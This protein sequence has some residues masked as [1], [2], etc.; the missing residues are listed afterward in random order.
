MLERFLLLW[1][2]ASSSVAYAWPAIASRLPSGLS[3]LGD[4]FLASKPALPGLIA[5]TMFC[6]GLMLPRDEVT[7]VFRRWPTVFGGTA[8]QYSVMPLFAFALGKLLGFS[9]PEFIG[10]V[11]VGCVP[12]AMASNV[13]T[14]NARGNT[15]YSVSLTTAATLLSPLVVP[16]VLAIALR[17]EQSVDTSVLQAASMMLLLTVVLPVLAGHILS[18]L[19]PSLGQKSRRFGAIVANLA[20]L[21]IIAVVVGRNRAHLA[22]LRADLLI[23]LLGV[24]LLGY[25]AGY[26]GGWGLR[27]PEAM[28]RALTLEVG[29]Q[30]AGLG[31]VLATA[32]FPDES[33]VAIAPAMYTFGCMLTGTMLARI[34]ASRSAADDSIEKEEAE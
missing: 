20:I 10:I 9:G 13:L 1:L 34:W 27:L 18:R 15:S 22:Q 16:A 31:A 7:Q 3:G 30:N 14:L 21:W 11:M 23:A 26:F 8:I 28:R 33:A 32:L 6:I 24:N 25:T 17:N 29:M 19:I 5:L 12:G 4:P 2:V